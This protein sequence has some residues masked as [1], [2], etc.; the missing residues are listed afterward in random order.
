MNN[1]SEKVVITTMQQRSMPEWKKKRSRLSVARKSWGHL[2]AVVMCLAVGAFAL[3]GDVQSREK[4]LSVM[5]SG[6]EYDETLGRLQY[7]S[8]ILPE[9]A[10]VFLS[11]SVTEDMFCF[12]TESEMIHV[13]S[14][15]E[16]WLEYQ[17]GSSICACEAGE[18]MTIVENRN[19]EYTVRIRHLDGYESVYSG[20]TT[21]AIHENSTVTAGEKIGYASETAAFELRRDGLSVLPVFNSM[22]ETP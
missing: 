14:Q 21:L 1:Q 5:T 2:A 22:E 13:W 15:E 20:L 8:N 6:F 10:M 18:V 19:N 11:T 4:A 7:V 16:P 12:P 9:Q 17:G 3:A